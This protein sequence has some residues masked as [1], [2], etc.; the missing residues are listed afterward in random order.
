M[1]ELQSEL[2]TLKAANNSLS[3][4]KE[5]S[6]FELR[7]LKSELHFMQESVQDA[8][9]IGAQLERTKNALKKA[10][11]NTNAINQRLTALEEDKGE[12]TRQIEQTEAKL[13]GSRES[14][15]RLKDVNSR[16]EEAISELEDEKSRLQSDS[17]VHAHRLNELE[18]NMSELIK[19]IKGRDERIVELEE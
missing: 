17:Q 2:D 1:H 11:S 12:L 13:R 14:E 7:K 3:K 5:V 8:Q 15:R 9:S 18:H 4:A 16:L 10:E 6:E 19:Q